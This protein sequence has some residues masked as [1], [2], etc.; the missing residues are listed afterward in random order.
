MDGPTFL[1]LI[2]FNSSTIG[3]KNI[4]NSNGISLAITWHFFGMK[5]NSYPTIIEE[6]Q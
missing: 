5:E 1:A 4:C 2:Y 3:L 6:E